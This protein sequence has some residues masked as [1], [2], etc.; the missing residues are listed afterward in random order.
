MFIIYLIIKFLHIHTDKLN[1][2]AVT[3]LAFKLITAFIKN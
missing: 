2:P 1:K 3:F